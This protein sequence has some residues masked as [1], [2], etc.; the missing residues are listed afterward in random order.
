MPDLQGQRLV[1]GA[2]KQRLRRH[3]R[4]KHVSP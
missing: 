1:S 2:E 4:R 3:C